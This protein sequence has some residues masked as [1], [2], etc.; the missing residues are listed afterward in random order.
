MFNK[1][2][3]LIGLGKQIAESIPAPVQF[4][5]I[6]TTTEQKLVKDM[7][8][9]LK[10]YK[11]HNSMGRFRQSKYVTTVVKDSSPVGQLLINKGYDVAVSGQPENGMVELS[12]WSPSHY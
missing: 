4:S 10:T 11:K 9:E 5:L 2:L 12:A 3:K 1:I 8:D 7:I 6:P